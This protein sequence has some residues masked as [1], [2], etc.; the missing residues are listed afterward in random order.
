MLP[1]PS[2]TAAATVMVAE[3]DTVET[4][5]H[6]RSA[7]RRRLT[8]KVSGQVRSVPYTFCASDSRAYMQGTRIDTA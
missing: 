1:S 5:A 8:S 6:R 7:R 2:V 4:K 3:A